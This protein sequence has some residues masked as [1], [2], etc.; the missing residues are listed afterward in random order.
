MMDPNR[1]GW[2]PNAFVSY[3]QSSLCDLR[4]TNNELLREILQ[5]N[6]SSKFFT[7]R[8]ISF[9]STYGS[10]S[11]KEEYTSIDEFREKVPL[12]T[13]EDYRDYIDRMAF[14]GENNLLCSENISYY[15]TTAGTTGKTKF[16]PVTVA[17]ME[18][19]SYLV[20]LGS[21]IL[22][23]SLPSSSLPSCRQRPFNL[24]GG[25]DREL[26]PKT[27]DGTPYGL[28][29]HYYS[30]V[31]TLPRTRSILSTNNTLTLDIIEK[32]MDFNTS[33]FIQLV[34]ALAHPDIFSY[35]VYFA[36]GFV[37]TIKVIENYF[38]EMSLCI[39]SA[40]FDQSSLVQ[41]H[42]SDADFR[43]ILNQALNEVTTEYGGDTYR[44]ERAQHIRTE[45][46]KHKVP[47]ILHRL[48]PALIFAQT[49]TGS[50]FSM[51]KEEIQFYCGEHLPLINL[52][53][54]GSSEGCFATIASIKTDEYILL[55]THAFFEFIKEEDVQ[56]VSF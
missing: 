12:T 16:L 29:S 35:T 25:R 32:I 52:M 10:V 27:K 44:L 45:C 42:I 4:T 33:V 49:A 19:V 5:D 18:K 17:T 2:D 14:E 3:Y 30:A 41:K 31:P 37:H 11:A 39:S 28:V 15:A 23:G 9:L 22:W 47:G 13:Y 21:A 20:Q 50:T 40:N 43:T 26:F 34:F 54:Y 38:E 51:Y 36:P 55:P 7:D 1:S 8:S 6:H 53:V 46:L 56:Q 48:W 24:L